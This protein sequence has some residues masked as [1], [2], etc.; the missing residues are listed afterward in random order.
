MESN[1][2]YKRVLIK[3]SGEFLKDKENI[4]SFEKL[5][6]ITSDIKEIQKNGV[7]IG[8]VVGGGN[9]LRGLE[10]SRKYQISSA[11][12]DELGMAATTINGGAISLALKKKKISSTVLS[13]I[14]ISSSVGSKYS[15][16]K[17]IDLLE[18][19]HIVIFVGG[20]GNPFFTTDTAAVL[21]ALQINADILLK[22][23]NVDGIYDKDPNKF[24]DAKLYKKLNYKDALSQNLKIMDLTAFSL[25]MEHN[26]PLV[27][28]NG[29][30]KNNLRKV[31]MGNNIGTIIK[32]GRNG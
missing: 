6:D 9:I 18:K 4:I 5:D 22:A 20:T 7:K 19:N 3:L 30:V 28:F 26:L 12:L 13:A 8:L 17:A 16:D 24:S 11:Q 15:R 27:V 2:K 29:K 25:A 31:I 10:G 1:P 21:R 14:P 23:T 32:G